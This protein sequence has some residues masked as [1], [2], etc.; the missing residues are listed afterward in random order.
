[1]KFLA[2]TYGCTMNQGESVELTSYLMRHGHQWVKDEDE[3]EVAL[4]NTCV[5]IAP[6]ER[7]VWRRLCQLRNSGK[8][9]IIIGCL[10]SIDRDRLI[11]EFPGSVVCGTA[12]YSSLPP[13]LQKEFGGA[14]ISLGLNVSMAPLILPI[15]QG[16]N[17]S[18]TYCMTKLARGDLD[19]YPIETLVERTKDALAQG[20][21][22]ILVTSQ[23]TAAYGMDGHNRLPDLLKAICDL[24]GD[25]RVRVGMMNPDNLKEIVDGVAKAF[26]HPKVYRFLHLPVQSGSDRIIREMG[27]AYSVQ[28]FMGMIER[29]RGAVPE[30]TVATDVI[31]GFPGETDQDHQATVEFMKQLRP[32]TINITRFSSRPGTVAEMMDGQVPGLI[33]RERSREMTALRFQISSEINVSR[34]GREY[35]V[36][37]DENGKNKSV[38]AR[39][40]DYMPVVIKG[41]HELWQRVT[42]KIT[43]AARTH[44]YGVIVRNMEN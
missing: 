44:L 1:M 31:T 11:Q 13:V 25:F 28:N 37:I 34:I 40:D 42:V 15:A 12:D 41:D 30:F 27:R 35:S 19:S 26:Q 16:C 24:P 36:L 10:A 2:E 21:K 29:M 9:L 3:A 14:G 5:V 22:E 23:D 18:C 17:G 43:A 33:S 7:K 8:R 39:T 6:T 4:I 20:V 32:N 38:I